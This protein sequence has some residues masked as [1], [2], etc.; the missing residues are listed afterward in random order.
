MPALQNEKHELFA[1]LVVEGLT[2]GRAYVAAGYSTKTEAKARTKGSALANTILVRARLAE[3]RGET[4]G[5]SP[6]SPADPPK[7]AVKRGGR[8]PVPRVGVRPKSPKGGQPPR[9]DRPPV[10]A[11]LPGAARARGN[12]RGKVTIGA[13]DGA[14]AASP[15]GGFQPDMADR[16]FRVCLLGATDAELAAVLQISLS[17]L[18]TWKQQYELFNDAINRGRLSADAH[19]AHSLYQRATGYRWV[20]QQA[21]KV[22]T[23]QYTEDIRIV[24]VEKAVPPDT[25]ANSLWMRNRHPDRWRERREVNIEGSIEHR[26]RQM[27][28]E[29]REQDA[30][31]LHQRVMS[32]LAELSAT[33]AES[34]DLPPGGET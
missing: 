3:L 5:L 33:D 19:V 32:R 22:K 13:D 15:K 20:E 26:L 9:D 10:L 24:E 1:R 14:P 29:Q 25:M 11:E 34:E 23:G 18:G 16:V 30:R 4:V 12:L 7:K 21:I 31:D 8:P 2:Q 17:T 28:P 27:T 6:T